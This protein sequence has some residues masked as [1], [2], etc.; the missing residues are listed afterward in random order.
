MTEQT[1]VDIKEETTVVSEESLNDGF[2]IEETKERNIEVVKGEI[3]NTA[4]KMIQDLIQ[5][6]RD[7][8]MLL[9][10]AAEE[11]PEEVTLEQITE[12]QNIIRDIDILNNP[13]ELADFLLNDPSTNLFEPKPNVY[14]LVTPLSLK[15]VRIEKFR[16]NCRIENVAGL[17]IKE[18]INEVEKLSS[19]RVKSRYRMV[20]NAFLY[21]FSRIEEI[22]K[23]TQLIILFFLVMRTSL[24]F[25]VL[26]TV[27]EF[28]NEV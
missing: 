12:A 4:T 22:K 10:K 18:V 16:S 1:V 20:I 24:R 25:K 3:T 13:K 21:R 9:I 5:G 6:I 14:R 11:K 27:T 8:N 19:I 2:G 7:Q 15:S 23:H 26:P 17:K 28:I